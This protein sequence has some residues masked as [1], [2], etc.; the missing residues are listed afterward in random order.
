MEHTYASLSAMTVAQLREIGHG[1]DHPD[2]QGIATMH[3]DKLLPILCRALGVEAHVHHEVVGID[4]AK[5][6]REIRDLK[7]E[8]TAALEGKD[9]EKLREVRERIHRL[10][11]LLRKATV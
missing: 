2:L 4:K 1:L 5:V 6:K 10:K 8:R 9:G 7:K 3:K 11:R